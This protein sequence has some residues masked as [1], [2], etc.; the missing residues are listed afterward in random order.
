MKSTH[1]KIFFVDDESAMRTAIAAALVKEGY[2]VTCF[3][4]AKTCLAEVERTGCNLLIS[5]VKMPG[6]DGLEL[7]SRMKRIA[8]WIPVILVTGYGNIQMAVYATKIGAAEFLEKPFSR[9][10][11]IE[12]VKKTIS[13]NEYDGQAAGLKLT[14]TEKKVLNMI[15][16]G[17]S[18]KEIALKMDCSVRS[19]EFHHTHIYR[20]FGVDNAV[21]LTKKAMAMFAHANGVS[22]GGA[23]S[24]LQSP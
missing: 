18:N 13:Q 11:F 8:P 9:E 1:P 16:S 4:N 23:A 7:L 5:D 24:V 19:V 6:M 21:D 3:A 12:K 14:K 2:E 22:S 17:L 20:K 15:L 10:L